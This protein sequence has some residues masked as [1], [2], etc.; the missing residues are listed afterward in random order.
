MGE[1]LKEWA[2]IGAGPAGCHFAISLLAGGHTSPSELTLLDSREPLSLWKQRTANCGMTFLRSSAVHHIGVSTAALARFEKRTFRSG[3]EWRGKARS[4]SLRLF[5]SHCGHL[6]QKYSLHRIWTRAQVTRLSRVGDTYRIFI[7]GEFIEA[8]RVV[9]ALGPVWNR[10]LPP[11][12]EVARD[13]TDFLLDPDFRYDEITGGQRLAVLGGGMTS[14][15]AALHLCR[16]NSVTLL[17]RAPIR[18]CEFDVVRGWMGPMGRSF[19]AQTPE[20]RRRIIAE[21]R[22]PGTVNRYVYATLRD[23]LARGYLSHRIL[24]SPQCSVSGGAIAVQDQGHSHEFDRIYI[25]TGFETG[26]HPLQETIAREHKAPLSS[27]GT[28]LLSARLE[29]LPGLFVVGCHAELGIGPAAG[30]LLGARLAA[31]KVLELA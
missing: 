7:G 30:N 16:K 1:Q 26:L 17:T 19:L 10:R 20:S 31:E 12:L 28:P 24:D 22:K 9:L 21:K 5:N 15:Q 8:R 25:G 18:V 14:V 2:I 11:W 4:P 13:Q 29:W 27:C 23:G 3:R 6:C